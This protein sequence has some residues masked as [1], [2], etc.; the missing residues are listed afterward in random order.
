MTLESDGS[1]L[2]STV[3]FFLD[4]QSYSAS[5]IKNAT[6]KIV[7]YVGY[8]RIVP[9]TNSAPERVELSCTEAKCDK[10]KCSVCDYETVSYYTNYFLPHNIGNDGICTECGGSLKDGIIGFGL[11]DISIVHGENEQL[12]KTVTVK[13]KLK[14]ARGVLNHLSAKTGNNN[15]AVVESVSKVDVEGNYEIVI[16]AISKGET[17][18]YVTV[19]SYLGK[20]TE[21]YKLEVK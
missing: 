14:Y 12:G 19:G 11:S 9:H 1:I 10:M 13:A 21:R 6:I 2:E 5:D 18:L 16:R 17:D 20:R 15:I 3:S 4:G 8:F 7:D